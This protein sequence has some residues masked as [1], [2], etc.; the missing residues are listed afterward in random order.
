MPTV[1]ADEAIAS[2]TEFEAPNPGDML[3]DITGGKDTEPNDDP[4]KKEPVKEP[5]KKEPEPEPKPAKEPP[6]KQL[7]EQYEATKKENA[8]LK[9]KLEAAEKVDNHP[10]VKELSEKLEALTRE[11]E[12]LSKK[13]EEYEKKLAISDPLANTKVRELQDKFNAE[14]SS[15]IEMVPEIADNFHAL[16]REFAALPREDRTAYAQALSEFETKLEDI[17]GPRKYGT[18]M[19]IIRKGQQFMG[20]HRKLVNE[21]QTD[22][23]RI[24]FEQQEKQWKEYDTEVS[25]ELAEALS[26]PEGLETSDPHSPLLFINKTL[27]VME[28][29]KRKELLEKVDTFARKLFAG[30]KPRSDKEY[31]GLTPEEIQQKQSEEA[32]WYKE[33]RKMG[34]RALKQGLLTLALQ[35]PFM[36][37]YAKMRDALERKSKANPPDPTAG[38]GDKGGGSADDDIA[39]FKPPVADLDRI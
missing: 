3:A 38:T 17:V 12:E 31:V 8:D 21:V 7:R 26:V 2:I 1:S 33:A 16:V 37:E 14:Y 35:R 25:S 6:A 32:Q 9:A 27:E 28:E 39:N 11:R 20:E 4:Q 29:P 18:A 13:T 34:V 23:K 10:K 36:A 15:A 24:A 19:D 5:D 22:A 30:Q